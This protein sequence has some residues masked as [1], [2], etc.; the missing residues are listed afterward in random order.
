M[1]ILLIQNQN[2]NQIQIQIQNNIKS[3]NLI[4]NFVYLRSTLKIFCSPVLLL[5]CSLQRMQSF[6]QAPPELASTEGL[7]S[8]SSSSV[9]KLKSSGKK[10]SNPDS[11][12]GSQS[13][14]DQEQTL[15]GDLKNLRL[16]AGNSNPELFLNISK[17]LGI[18]LTPEVVDRFSNGEIRVQIKDNM[19]RRVAVIMQTGAS[20]PETSYSVN[21]YLMEILLLANTCRLSSVD[22]I[23]AIVPCFFY[24]RQDKKD[25]SRTP[26]SGRVVADLMQ[27]AGINRV[28]T[29]DLH[30]SQIAGFFSIPVD[31]L[32]AV[33]YLAAYIRRFYLTSREETQKY[34]LVSPDNGGTKRIEALAQRVDLPTATMHKVRDYVEKNKVNKTVLVGEANDVTGKIPIIIDD[35]CDT[36]GTVCQACQTLI[37]FGAKEVIIMVV[38]GVF[39]GPGI[40]RLNERPYIKEVVTTNTLPQTSNLK[41]CPKLK[42][43]DISPLFGEA[44]YRL[45]TG[46]SISELFT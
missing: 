6:V 38:H 2:Q 31:N 27:T 39:S 37:E 3:K 43:I 21:D 13:T 15:P 9:D 8:S 20:S 1:K 5:S 25:S 41:K 14:P 17:Y 32:Y 42:V 12:Q 23:V 29:M 34:V 40:D 36:A 33:K 35:M 16:L 19:R 26:I 24:A 46:G 22:E 7:K 45:Y 28:V 44:I 18:S 11:D 4:T 10:R 30:A